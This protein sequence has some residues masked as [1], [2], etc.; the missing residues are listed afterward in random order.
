ML[1]TFLLIMC[2]WPGCVTF[3]S[4]SIVF[5]KKNFL[6]VELDEKRQLGVTF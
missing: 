1:L 5:Q 3:I 2:L 4:V 6:Q